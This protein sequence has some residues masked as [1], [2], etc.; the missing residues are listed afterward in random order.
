[1]KVYMISMLNA[2][3][4]MVVGLWGYLGDEASTMLALIPVFTGAL[5]LSLVHGVRYGSKSMAL[6]SLILTSLILIAMIMP[7]I[8]AVGHADSPSTY[9]IG[10]MM[11]SSSI[12]T[13][14]FIRNVF[15][16]SKKKKSKVKARM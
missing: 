13:G 14:Y 7:L 6:L 5:L 2:F 12:A 10:F 11:M 3:V 1:M 8:S 16:K 4:L 15:L 9:R